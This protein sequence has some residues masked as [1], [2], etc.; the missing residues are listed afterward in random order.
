MGRRLGMKIGKNLQIFFIAMT[1]LIAATCFMTVPA[2][3]E[4]SADDIKLYN[5]MTAD[6]FN[7]S[8]GELT[9]SLDGNGFRVQGSAAE[10]FSFRSTGASLYDGFGLSFNMTDF[11]YDEANKAYNGK[12]AIRIGTHEDITAARHVEITLTQKNR[13]VVAVL[14]LVENGEVVEEL[15]PVSNVLYDDIYSGSGKNNV[16]L[17]VGTGKDF[18]IGEEG[19]QDGAFIDF[20]L[21]RLNCSVSDGIKMNKNSQLANMI[22]DIKRQPTY[23]S[24][25]AEGVNGM[26]GRAYD[27]TVFQHNDAR[28][29][30]YYGVPSAE[31]NGEAA[32]NYSNVSIKWEVNAYKEMDYSG[33]IIKRVNVE[34]DAVEKE[35]TLNSRLSATLNDNRL[36]QATT[37]RYLI[38]AYKNLT[39]PLPKTVL[40]YNPMTVVTRQGDMTS[41]IMIVISCVIVFILIVFIYV[42]WYDIVKILKRKRRV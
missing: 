10:G 41:F 1:L 34:T 23:F 26:D 22:D 14:A 38:T 42:F 30:D 19:V 40:I 9:L 27:M 39:T 8:R 24:V 21:F 16:Q 20:Y 11:L 4:A 36:A 37:Y 29:Y 13:S 7:C 12:L 33:F 15:P 35:L 2:K 25:E 17:L 18:A 5:D 32:V 31:L 6:Y 28:F 3:A